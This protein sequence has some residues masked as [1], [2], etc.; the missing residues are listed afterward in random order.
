MWW[1]FACLHPEPLPSQTSIRGELVL[2]GGITARLSDAPADLVV[3]YG[4]EQRGSLETCG[5]PKLPRGSLARMAA[6]VDAL[7]RRKE[8]L[9][10]VNPGYWLED[11][12]G[13]QGELRPD[14]AAMDR[15]MLKGLAQLPWTALNL[16]ANDLAAMSHV[17]G[18]EE[19][20]VVSAN[21]EG[22][23]ASRIITVNGVRVGITGITGLTP[24]LSDPKYMLKDPLSAGATVEALAKEVDVLI[25]LAWQATD[26]AKKLAEKYPE[27]DV[28][29]DA[30]SYR[31]FVPPVTVG[32]AVWVFSHT[33]TMRLGELRLGLKDGAV[34]SAVDRKI[35]MDPA[36]ADQPRVSSIARQARNEINLL[37]KQLYQ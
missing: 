4:G 3:V 37:Q 33:Q 27:V 11:A 24:T 26:A 10:L 7:E 34:V 35:D 5:C 8:P 18:A 6:Y 9:I 16:S 14:V 20:P 13:F 25:L 31:D 32:H 19:L 36:I 15:W 17:E 1:L 2:E 28:V 30:A 23:N 22:A 12:T 29:V 21:A